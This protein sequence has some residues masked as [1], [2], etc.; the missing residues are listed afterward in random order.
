MADSEG[1]IRFA[2]DLQPSVSSIVDEELFAQLKAWRTILTK[3]SLLGRHPRRYD[4]LGFG[5]LSLRDPERP[6]EF[7]ITASQSSGIRRID[8]RNITR[9]TNYNLQRFWVDACGEEPPSSE[10]MTHAMIYAADPRISWVF[11]AHSPEIWSRA[12]ALALPCTPDTAV[13]GSG[14]LVQAVSDLLNRY[15][16]RPIVFATLGHTDGIFACGPT[17]RD[18]GGLL[19]S[20]LAKSLV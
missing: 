7:I 12:A 11:H 9:I 15:H 10:T 5:N 4:G 14:E 18:A 3:L 6:G 13:N 2:Y 16:S 1:I 8:Q 17:A 20:Y 19:V